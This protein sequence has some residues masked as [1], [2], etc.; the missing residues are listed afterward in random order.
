M[1]R[2]GTYQWIWNPYIWIAMGGLGHLGCYK[3]IQ[4]LRM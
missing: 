1:G 3:Y 2:H 4:L